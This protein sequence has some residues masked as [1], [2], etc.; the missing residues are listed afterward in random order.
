MFSQVADNSEHAARQNLRRLFIL[1]NLMIFSG[2]L[3]IFISTFGLRVQLPAQPLWLVITLIM[4]ANVYTWFR[5]QMEGTVTEGE[6]FGQLI[7]DVAAITLLLYLTGGASN[8]IAW[9]FLLPVII[10]AI[11]L[12]Q[13]YA[14]YMVILTTSM[15]TIL[16]S[17]NVPL[18]AIEP[19]APSMHNL[20]P[21]MG[22]CGQL[23]QAHAISDR[24]YFNLH[25][26][27]M[28]FGFVFS[29]GLVAYFVVELAG[30][31]RKQ[32]RILAEAREN[33]L[34][35]ERVVALGTLAASAA[36]DMGT[37]LGTIAIVAHELEN[38]YPQHR[39]PDLHEKTQIIQQQIQRCK[40][41]LS[42]MSA[43]AGELRAE[44]GRVVSVVE[45][46]DD[47]IKQWRTHKPGVKLSFFVAQPVDEEAKVIA[48]RTLTH[49]I[50]NILNNAAEAS[51][52]N[53]GIELHAEWDSKRL[54]LTVRDFG[55]G[56]PPEL[57]E[58]AGKLPV[59]SKKRGLGV[60]LFLT[61]STV[62][63]LGGKIKLHNHEAGGAC[64]ELSLPLFTTENDDDSPG[65][66]QTALTAG[67]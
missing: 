3:L 1:R 63:R 30:A 57:T 18:P 24:H 49:S 64:V 42:V 5:L 17:F 29:A 22:T 41:A 7:I 45:Y 21:G 44:S 67:R 36:H 62:K 15:Y 61:Y 48:E 51:P 43:S 27:G 47:I 52:P 39:L 34:R 46:L 60:G 2:S 8:P 6:L 56:L 54:G 40:A 31:L 16:M 35:D 28:W 20:N 11:M 33:A 38:E 19:H 53:Q 13:A 50:I 10:S 4:A 58:M 32:E 9:V 26:F 14:W 55:A 65:Y 25:V 23:L 12:P 66:G 37:P 59:I